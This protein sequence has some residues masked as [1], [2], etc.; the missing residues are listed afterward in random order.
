VG[1]IT[2]RITDEAIGKEFP[3]EEEENEEYDCSDAANVIHNPEDRMPLKNMSSVIRTASLEIKPSS[4][5]H[6]VETDNNHQLQEI[7]Q[8]KRIRKG[9]KAKDNINERNKFEKQ[10]RSILESLCP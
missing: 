6:F 7:L 3:E 2:G 10:Y 9:I 4:S 1:K 5:A 8:A